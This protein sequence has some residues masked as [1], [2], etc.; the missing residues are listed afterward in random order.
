MNAADRWQR[1]QELFER[2]LEREPE[3]R[4]AYVREASGGDAALQAEIDE[5][6]AADSR[7]SDEFLTDMIGEVARDMAEA[8]AA[9]WEGRTVGPY[10]LMGEIARGGMGTV[11]LAERA[12]AAYEARVA[13][14]FVRGSVAGPELLSRFLA[15]RQILADL[16]HPHIARLVDG[17][18]LDDGTPY[19]VMEH[20]EGEPIDGY[21]ERHRLDTRARLTLFRKV[22]DAVQHAHGRLVVHRDIKPSNIL[23]TADGTPKLLDFG[24]AKLLDPTSEG[25]VTQTGGAVGLLTPAYASPEQVRGEPITTATD[26]YS[27]GVLLYRLLTGAL[28]Y[29]ADTRRG[30][31]LARAITDETPEAPSRVAARATAPGEPRQVDHDADAIVLTALAKERERRYVSVQQ[32]SED[33]GRLLD[34]KPVRARPA[35]RTYRLSKFVARHRAGVFA[36][37]TAVALIAGLTGFYTARLA[38]ERD[39][40]LFERQK[41]EQVAGFLERLFRVSDPSEARG[42]TITAREVLDSAVAHLPAELSD[43]PQV[44]AAMLY[45]LGGVYANLGLGRDARPLLERGLTLRHA[46]P[47][48]GSPTVGDFLSRLGGIELDLGQFD[49]AAV[50][51]RQAVT[52]LDTT[53]DAADRPIEARFT[54]TNA[55]RRAGRLDEADTIVSDAVVRARANGAD[56]LV[57]AALSARGALLI[58]RRRGTEAEPLLREALERYR[59]LLGDDEPRTITTLSNLGQA[60][61]VQTRFA[62]AEPIM[63]EVLA[64]RRR[65]FGEEHPL[66]GTAWNNLSALLQS[67]GRPTDAEPAARRA[68][69]I[70]RASYGEKHQRVT[71]VMTNLGSMLLAMG[72]L[73]EAERMHREALAIMQEILRPGHINIAVS[74]NNLAHVLEQGRRFGEAERMFRAALTVMEDGAGSDSPTGSIFLAN[75]GRVLDL[76]DRTGE[77]EQT[78]RRALAIQRERFPARHAR[79]ATTLTLLGG[80]LTRAGR[81][82][83]AEPML[84]E[85]LDMRTELLAEDHW[86]IQVTRSA[87]GESVAALGRTSDAEELLTTSAAALEERLGVD[88]E[89]TRAAIERAAGFYTARGDRARADEYTRRL[90]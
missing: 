26:I 43:Q 16:T 17:G 68:L 74:Y 45:T 25:E 78:L 32:L 77:A 57:A 8:D 46:N 29:E 85:A 10:R 61:Y 34:G 7:S 9:E 75:L 19:L 54:L 36:G 35:T 5:L 73:D 52:A 33:V 38:S 72:R 6:L 28:P 21:V 53:R 60:L 86:A 42:A 41:A 37:M 31:E 71:M 39:A 44:R 48:G 23:V 40:A 14:K 89:R 55:L 84:R 51:L 15:E 83:E 58:T 88:D 22:C 66:T 20:I 63:R 12:D 81:A 50:L 56:S 47:A 62:D 79:T 2:A 67:Q 76:Q 11:Y 69:E 70:Y 87:L 24:V 1:V 65:V 90:R 4:E 64:L 13:I 18:A 80:L 59:A 27:L 82:T 49:S 30:V 3:A